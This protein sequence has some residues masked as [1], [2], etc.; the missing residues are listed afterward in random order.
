MLLASVLVLP[1]HAIPGDAE[2]VPVHVDVFLTPGCE[3]CEEVKTVDL[4]ALTNALG[5]AV[6]VTTYDTHD[7]D[8]F[9]LLTALQERAAAP[10]P[11]A[12]VF[13]YVNRRHQ[14]AGLDEIRDRLVDLAAQEFS[15]QATPAP[16]PSPADVSTEETV[17]GRF[18]DFTAAAVM[19]AGL[20]DG[21]NPCAFAT[22]VF[23]ITLLTVSHRSA[24]AILATGS[25]FCV[26]VFMT[27]F[28]LG[29]GA[30]QV[31][32]ALQRLDWLGWGIRVLTA[33]GLLVL[34]VLSL[35]DAWR[36]SRSGKAADVTVQIPDAIKTRIHATMRRGIKR[37]GLVAGAV[38]I[39]IL[40]TLL[41]S[42]CTGQV[43]L[44]TLV[45]MTE[46]NAY[47]NRAWRLLI[48]YNLA[49]VAPLV[50]ILLATVAGTSNQRLLAWSRRNVVWGKILMAT[51][52]AGLAI[53]LTFF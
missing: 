36:Y 3:Q 48:L 50:A 37:H 40:V 21:V 20:V 18:T 12:T 19:A 24:R 4:P 31:L 17:S 23:F 28:L 7:R 47:S 49:F 39:G 5:D 11:N 33:A 13:V 41:E 15:E 29:L 35:R 10:P 46:S 9:L 6:V 32:H 8:D 26:A 22:M 14:L 52:F 45:Y 44:P 27:Y 2:L 53:L 51:L 42:V 34:A 30:F 38:I 1:L 16:L 25:V 43:Y